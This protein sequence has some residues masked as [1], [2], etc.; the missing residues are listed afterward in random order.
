MMRGSI[1]RFGL[2]IVAVAILLSGFFSL[3]GHASAA[4]GYA[5]YVFTEANLSGPNSVLVFGRAADGSLTQ[6]SAISTGGMGTGSG[7]GSEGALAMSD[8]GNW[9]VA[10][11]AGSNDIA[12]ISLKTG[13]TVSRLGS[14]GMLPTSVTIHKNLVY[15]LN[16][17]SD[18]I[19]GFSLSNAGL[20]S[21]IPGSTQPLSGAGVDAKQVRFSTDGQVLVVTEKNTNLIDTYTVGNDG[22]ATGHSSHA[23]SGPAP[24]GF[25]FGK[26]N[27]LVVSEAA[28]SAAS[29]YRVT[30]SGGV[31]L[32]SGSV[33]NGQLAAC[34][35]VVTN[36]GHFAYT[37]D[38]HNG[39]ISGYRVA[40]NGALTL[41][42]PSG[43]SGTTGGTPLDEAMS[44]NDKFLYVLN[45]GSGTLG[46]D[47]FAV[48][49]DGS[50]TAMAN[51]TGTPASASGLVA[52]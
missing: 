48:N 13:T 10:V 33:T 31:N 11:D 6:V 4:G 40:G 17:D 49:S 38:A 36:D 23:S 30:D 37:A 3:P 28:N 16:H 39:M 12:V 9:L 14:G 50:L 24:F 20:L 22:A 26:R 42:D 44:L 1:T 32:V 25:D 29:S 18:N 51:T 47:A 7:I 27:T 19:T 43:I 15:V 46:I 35:V 2:T 52:R 5:G 41:L 34:W 21:P 8:G 45:D